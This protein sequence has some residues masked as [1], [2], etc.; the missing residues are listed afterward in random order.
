M[1]VINL[2]TGLEGFGADMAK[3]GEALTRTL[4]P[5][6]IRDAQVE[7]MVLQNPELGQLLAGMARQGGPEAGQA[8][9]ISPR[10]M[11]QMGQSFAPTTE[12]Q[13]NRILTQDPNY[14]TNVADAARVQPRAATAT[15]EATIAGAQEQEATALQNMKHN[16]P[17]IQ[18][19][20]QAGQLTFLDRLTTAQLKENL[21]EAQAMYEGAGL[22]LGIQEKKFAIEQ[23]DE[24]RDWI[25]EVHPHLRGVAL[26]AAVNP[27]LAT[28]ILAHEQMGF[29]ERML[30]V[31]M[32]AEQDQGLGVIE[33]FKLQRDLRAEAND[34][35]DRLRVANDEGNEEARQRAVADI[36]NVAMWQRR[37]VGDGVLP[38]QNIFTA[39]MRERLIRSGVGEEVLETPE[40]G[41]YFESVIDQGG[42][43]QELISSNEWQTARHFLPAERQ[44]E[45][46]QRAAT[47]AR[48]EAPTPTTRERVVEGVQ[49]GRAEAA[50]RIAEIERVPLS[51]R[52]TKMKKELIQLKDRVRFGGSGPSERVSPTARVPELPTRPGTVGGGR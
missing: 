47:G 18:A 23:L 22:D 44:A 28:H 5:G 39:Q 1:A 52:T 24:Y 33:L 37:L 11:G 4:F 13:V 30:S 2:P 21:P 51:D 20:A 46:I 26:A 10:L 15:G 32:A 6:T 50:R 41:E 9:G 16:I 7:Q 29:E 48:P 36:E 49:Q 19:R 45:I 25:A 35:S 27:G 42:T 3:F 14:I 43:L 38:G 12:E 17:E 40:V 34:A 31:R 8:M